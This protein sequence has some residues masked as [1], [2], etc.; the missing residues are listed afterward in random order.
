MKPQFSNQFNKRKKKANADLPEKTLAE[1]FELMASHSTPAMSTIE[2]R[3]SEKNSEGNGQQQEEKKDVAN[4][5][6]KAPP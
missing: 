3:K 6:L 2:D 1:Q 4:S 5:P